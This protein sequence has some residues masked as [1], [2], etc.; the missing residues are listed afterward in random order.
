MHSLWWLRYLDQSLFI[1]GAIGAV[2]ITTLLAVV[3]RCV[4]KHGE[5]E[6]NG[7]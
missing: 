4:K 6:R 5:G 2:F 7:N 1:A 3:V